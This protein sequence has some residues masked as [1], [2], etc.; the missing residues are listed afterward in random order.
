MNRSLVKSK[1]KDQGPLDDWQWIGEDSAE[2]C[3]PRTA[4]KADLGSSPGGRREEREGRGI[5]PPSSTILSSSIEGRSTQ[6]AQFASRPVPRDVEEESRSFDRSRDYPWRSK[7]VKPRSSD[8]ERT[9]LVKSLPTAKL[10]GIIVSSARLIE[11]VAAT[12]GSPTGEEDELHREI[13]LLR[14]RNAVRQSCERS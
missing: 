11:K 8:E 10:T 1:V 13:R 3:L 2:S 4:G 6:R 9:G 14:A 5:R 12:T 7:R